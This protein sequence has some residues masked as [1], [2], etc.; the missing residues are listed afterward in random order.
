MKYTIFFKSPKSICPQCGG[1]LRQVYSDEIILNCIDCNSFF[2]AIGLGHAEA[3]LEF[4]EV[5]VR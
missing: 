2:R 4:E 5:Q 3:E 1:Q